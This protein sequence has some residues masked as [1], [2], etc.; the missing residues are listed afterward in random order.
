MRSHPIVSISRIWGFAAFGG[1]VLAGTFF[2][3]SA[4]RSQEQPATDDP[5]ASNE[6]ISFQ[7][8]YTPVSP[9]LDYGPFAVCFSE[10]NPPTGDF[11]DGLMRELFNAGRLP[12]SYHLVHPD[13]AAMKNRFQLPGLI[14]PN[15]EIVPASVVFSWWENDGDNGGGNPSDRYFLGS[16]WSGAQGSP[17]TLTW[18]FAKDNMSIPSGIGEPAGANLLF[19]RMDTLFASQ[20]GRA[21]WILRYQQCFDRWSQVTGLTYTRVMQ[22]PNG[23]GNDEDDDGATYFTSGGSA[24]LRGDVRIAMH[25]IDGTNGILAYNSFPS[26][27]DMVMDSSENWGSSTNQH[28]FFRNTVMHEHGHGIGLQHVC[29]NNQSFLMEPLLQTSFDGPRHD[30]MRGGQRHYGDPQEID[31]ASATATDLG[32]IAVNTTNNSACN[33]PAP[34]TGTN[35]T[36]TSNCSIDANGEQDYFKFTVAANSAANI[37]VT[38]VGF[39]YDNN[40]QAGDGSCPSGATTNSL[41]AANLAVE[42][43]GTDG[44]TILA[45]ASAQALGLAETISNAAL[46]AAGTY[47]VRVFESDAPTLVQMYTLSVNI[48]PGSAA[49]AGDFNNSGTRD[50]SDLAI[51][52]AHFGGSGTGVD[53]DMDGNGEI[54]LQDLASFLAVFGSPC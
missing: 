32:S 28:R 23:D 48:V 9:D 17:R 19:S 22:A 50:L 13:G 35:P 54:T 51:L 47:F 36:S 14:R 53:G 25:N 10:T 4:A 18:S 42:L 45:S 39:S 29:S 5:T 38:P 49:C 52:L 15:G 1:A 12:E 43:R 26:Q 24:G 7:Q 37:T 3:P 6:P 31:D 2:A 30:D 46:P 40:A 20:G 41:Q 8:W 44:T 34:Q 16:R 11:I 27:G 21:T 33:I